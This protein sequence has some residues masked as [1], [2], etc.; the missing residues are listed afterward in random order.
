MTPARHTI[1]TPYMVGPVH[2][3]SGERG[4]D[5]VL[6]DTGP[7]T[8]QCRHY[9]Q[10][11]IDLNRLK[12]VLITHCHIDHYGQVAWLNENCGATIYL[13][14]K[15][16]EK[17]RNHARRMDE[18]YHLLSSLGFSEE[19]LNELRKIFESGALF[20]PF[21]REYKPVE[22]SL[23]EHLGI[24]I[25][26]CPGHS[27]SDL[28]YVGEEW[29]I[30]GDTLLRGVF[31]SPLLDV[32]L[33][34]GKRFKN[35]ETYTETLRKL[36][37]LRGKTILPGH[38]KRLVSIDETLV[39]YIS[40]ML[41]R[42]RHFLPFRD[43]DN[44]IVIIDKM[45]GNRVTDVFHMYLKASEIVFMRD[46]LQQPD[47]LRTSLEEIGLFDRLAPLFAAATNQES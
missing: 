44:L 22:T 1:N 29:A 10:E 18:M 7:P 21:P 14:V 46:F 28:V 47:L 15:D 6:F 36:A 38:R 13:P 33:A 40:K 43:I 26:S 42:V 23:P 9:L 24:E 39:F 17:I 25:V 5:L 32:D 45:L 16:C 8:A 12:H 4:G 3:Y 20:P 34:T 11:N 41:S 37:A 19:S 31:Q 2:C 27:Q 35:Y 30:T